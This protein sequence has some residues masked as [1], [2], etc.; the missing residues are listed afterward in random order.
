MRTIKIG[1]MFSGCDGLALAVQMVTLGRVVWH[2]E[3]EP[4][5]LKVLEAHWPGVPNLGDVSAIDWAKV[6]RPDVLVGGFPCQ[7]ISL[8]GKG[9]GIEGERSGLWKCIVDAVR[10]LRPPPLTRGE[11]YKSLCSRIRCSHL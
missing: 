9:A 6:E 11:R 8:A 5:G 10:V 7:D 2:E 4:H 3:I 1:S